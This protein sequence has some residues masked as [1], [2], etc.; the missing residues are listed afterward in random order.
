MKKLAITLFVLVALSLSTV[1][2]LAQDDIPMGGTVLV[3]AS[4]QSSWERNF[5][6]YAP[7]PTE[8]A[9]RFVY[10]PLL[11]FNPVDGGAATPWLV[12]EYMY[13]D[14]MLML[15][16]KLREGV[17]WSDG[18]AFDADDV[19]FSF[20]LFK[21]YP[22]TDRR[23]VWDFLEAV[24]KVDDYTVE[25]T[26]NKV[27]GEAFY[28]LGLC[29]MVPEHVWSEIEDPVLFTNP[30]PIATG[31]FANVTN[32]S[33]Q[34]F[35]LCRNE[36]YWQ[37]GKPYVDCLR[38]PAYTDN[39]AANLALIDDDLDWVGNFIPDVDVTYVEVNPETHGYYFWPGGAPHQV[40]MNTTAAPFDDLNFR[41]ALSKGINYD[42]VI[43]IGE[44]GYPIPI[45][46]TGLGPRYADWISEEAE[47]I[48]EEMGIG[49]YDPDGAV[50]ILD[51]NG[52]VD[53]DG[54]GWRDLPNGDPIEFDIQVVNGWTDWV[55]SAQI[56]TQNYQDIGLNANLSTPEYGAW[57]DNLNNGTYDMSWSWATA[58]RTPW[59]Y[60][61]NMLDSAFIQDDGTVIQQLWSRWTSDEVDQLLIDF[62]GTADTD[63]QMD[64]LGQ[65]QVAFVENVPVIPLYPAPAWYEYNTT[66]VTGFPTED[67]YYAQ[68]SP[69]ENEGGALITSLTIHCID[70]VSC[71]QGE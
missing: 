54:D 36:Y 14:D 6:P 42:A 4:P 27:F 50:A 38:F 16:F 39:D 71:G 63:E 56:V 19:I 62:V 45:S 57:I 22:A 7:S 31:P 48:A 53:A 12:E 23:A 15:T 24:E 68:G 3:Q 59:N 67:D 64:I 55:T 34:V 46:P 49:G 2:G 37:E 66:R 43:N 1:P 44:Y 9:V 26:L 32:F 47:A 58:G 69:W 17:M 41:I 60:Y 8:G 65:I 40:Y 13:S 61:R 11:V 20:N 51:E 21:E 33:E 29:L 35:E 25:F 5:N 30:E 28:E 10:E 52:Y 70:D 18:E